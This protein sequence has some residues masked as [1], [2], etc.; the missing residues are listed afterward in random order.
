MCTILLPRHK[1]NETFTI[2]IITEHQIGLTQIVYWLRRYPLVNSSLKTKI[3]RI[4]INQ[5][6]V[7]LKRHSHKDQGIVVEV[8]L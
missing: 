8:L 7:L 1:W 4:I 3:I 6:D 2:E 5:L